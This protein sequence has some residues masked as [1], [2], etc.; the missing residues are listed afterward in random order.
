MWSR[1]PEELY[2]KINHPLFINSIF[3]ELGYERLQFWPG[4]NVNFDLVYKFKLRTNEDLTGSSSI[5]ER[6]INLTAVQFEI[7]CRLHAGLDYD[8]LLRACRKELNRRIPIDELNNDNHYD[9]DTIG[10][11]YKRNIDGFLEPKGLV[12]VGEK[13]SKQQIWKDGVL[14][15]ERDKEFYISKIVSGIYSCHLV[16]LRI[17]HEDGREEIQKH[18]VQS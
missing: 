1:D 9:E 11:A 16:N 3:V 2:Y 12:E 4:N 10:Y 15:T 5:G 14:H 6:V 17:D 7:M 8:F 13:I 18:I